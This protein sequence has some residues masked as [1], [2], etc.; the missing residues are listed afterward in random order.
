MP[1]CGSGLGAGQ[2]N[3]PW[4]CIGPAQLWRDP[5]RHHKTSL[6]D[7]TK[8]K[9]DSQSHHG[10]WEGNRLA[11][12]LEIISHTGTLLP[13]NLPSPFELWE[14]KRLKM[15]GEKQSAKGT[16]PGTIITKRKQGRQTDRAHRGQTVPSQALQNPLS[17]QQL[18]SQSSS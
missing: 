1:F 2:E 3:F 8:H 10:L 17:I 5:H 16:Y 4:G 11:Q 13:P 7:A 14:H 12:K 15:W 18:K 6:T 9:K